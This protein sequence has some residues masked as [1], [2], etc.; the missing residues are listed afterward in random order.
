MVSQERREGGVVRPEAAGQGSR[1]VHTV[2]EGGSPLVRV[3]SRGHAWTV[4][5]PPER[6]GT[7][8]GA[9]PV[10][11]FLGALLSC[12]TVSFKSAAR[13]HN[14]TV[15]R[16]EGRAQAN[17]K[18]YITEVAVDL[19]VWS[20]DPEPEVQALLDRAK[21]GCFVGA[22]MRPEIPYTVALRVHASGPGPSGAGAAFNA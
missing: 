7:D 10:E 17:P 20:P 9:T 12:L 4:D 3:E 5:E 14:V 13:R 16:I 6:G 22:V 2:S 18:G 19:D 1:V 15:D 8:A 11:T 21:R